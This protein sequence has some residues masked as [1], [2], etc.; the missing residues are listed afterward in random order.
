MGNIVSP[1]TMSFETAINSEIYVDKT[2]M[3][4]YLNRVIGTKQRFV[5]VSRPRR[6]GKTTAADMVCAYYDYSVGSA[7]IFDKYV[8]SEDESFKKHMNKYYVIHINMLDYIGKE[9]NMFQ[10]LQSDILHE[11]YEEG[12]IEEG[13]DNGNLKKAIEKSFSKNEKQFIFVIDEWDCI[14]RNLQEETKL[15]KEYLDFLR[16]LLK[17]NKNIALVYMTGILPIKKYGEHSALNMFDEFS[18]VDAGELSDYVGFTD[19]EAKNLCDK[20]KVDYAKVKEWYD[21]YVLKYKK[22][23][24]NNGEIVG[25]RDCSVNLY[26][27]ESVVNCMMKGDFKNY[28]N[29]TETIEALKVHIERNEDGL[30]EIISVLINGGR[31]KVNIKKYQNDMTTFVSADDVLTLLIHLGYLGYDS[32]TEEVFIPNKEILDEYKNSVER[33]GKW[34]RLFAILNDSERLLIATW[35]KDSE[36]V[37]ELLEYAHDRAS[38]MTYNSEAALSYAVQLAYYSAHNYYTLIQEL[39]T[40]KGY[41]DLV[42]IPAPEHPD[43]PALLIELKYDESAKTAITQ[44]EKNNYPQVLEAYKGNLIVVGISYDKDADS[45]KYNYKHHSCI[46]KEL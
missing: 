35:E 24:C 26:S 17:D 29:A 10:L 30:S 3:L 6:F 7:A 34:N 9:K 38:N 37:A 18:M 4:A 27:P 33:N 19:Y 22:R 31:Y 41:A 16:D 5:C 8:I 20:Y 42:Y 46:I 13:Y 32:E 15:Q 1:G 39:D 11:L 40:G 2:G 45:K 23:E 21:G 25:W 43:K 28:W 44:I 36:T 14:F 12:I